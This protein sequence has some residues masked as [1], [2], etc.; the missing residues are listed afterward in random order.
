MI[1]TAAMTDL[2]KVRIDLSLI[3][4]APAAGELLWAQPLGDNLFRLRN[5]PSFA[6]G[7]SEG[8]VVRCTEEN[9]V[10]TVSSLVH[11]SGN[12][13]IRVYF[14]GESAVD[15]ERVFAA[16]RK[17][18]CSHEL[19]HRTLVMFTVPAKSAEHFPEIARVLNEEAV[20][21]A[22]EI[23]KQPTGVQADA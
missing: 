7:L 6:F 17:R 10:T 3:D 20:V 13:A 9:G 4:G 5:I 2:R 22:W 19:G 23:G 18:G 21:E 14:R 15:R 16:L 8:D 11:D 1:G 12:G